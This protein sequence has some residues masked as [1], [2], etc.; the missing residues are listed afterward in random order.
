VLPGTSNIIIRKEYIE[1]LTIQGKIVG[2]RV[3]GRQ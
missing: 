1:L 3:R 2:K